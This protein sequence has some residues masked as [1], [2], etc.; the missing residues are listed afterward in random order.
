MPIHITRVRVTN[1]RN[2]RAV[3]LDNLASAVALFGENRQGKTSLL[4]AV[5][6][7][8]FGWCQ[9]TD[10]RGSHPERLIRDGAKSA[11]VEL[12]LTAGDSVIAVVMELKPRGSEWIA[13]AASGEIVARK[14]EELWGL[15]G[16]DERQ[17]QVCA[18][19]AL[20]LESGEAAE[21]MAATLVGHIDTEALQR[22]FGSERSWVTD[23]AAKKRLSLASAQDLTALGDKAYTER[24]EIRR[25]LKDAQAQYEPAPVPV[26]V[27][28]RPL[29]V[30]DLT[31]I[32]TGV[33]TVEVRRSALLVEQGR[34]QAVKPAAE[35]E[36]ELAD[37]QAAVERAK[38]AQ[39]EAGN[40]YRE[41]KADLSK[42]DD[43]LQKAREALGNA[44]MQAR[45][46]EAEASRAKARLDAV[47]TEDG[48]CPTCERK[49]TDALP[50][51]LVE[52]LDVC[53]QELGGLAAKWAEAVESSGLMVESSRT[54]K[55]LAAQRECD[56]CEAYESAKRDLERAA[57]R[58]EDLAVPAPSSRPAADIEAELAAVESKL[59]RG[60]ELVAA[61]E[62]LAKAEDLAKHIAF[63]EEELAHL[64]WAV[65]S[66]R[67]GELTKAFMGSGLDAFAARATAELE[68]FGYAL[69]VEVD[70]KR[71]TP[72]L[73]A[74][75][76]AP[77]PLALCSQGEQA[78]AALSVAL[79]FADCGAPVLVDELNTLDHV[80]RRAVL[81]R[82]REH[83]GGSL[84]VAGAWQSNA[85]VAD[86]ASALDPATV[87]WVQ[88]G[89]ASVAAG[90]EEAA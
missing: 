18:M 71:V 22:E 44:Q 69:R 65:K 70:G 74:A 33:A 77:R 42:A 31:R 41:A 37:A 40:I 80:L 1:F 57:Q 67:D 27:Q 61:L 26:D 45:T 20:Y 51:K 53:L 43:A 36:A 21:V 12:T 24:T 73:C 38:Q 89:A 14:R 56:A 81:K 39:V 35:S 50:K 55:D 11:T 82:L 87:V 19:P 17:A 32:R 47:Q 62:A 28:G 75:G 54:A 25:M 58:L 23:Y 16:V 84:W 68:R 34:A 46:A 90:K 86:L 52:P 78:L 88:D 72:A 7:A 10:R 3:A 30:G 59:A 85:D 29:T 79:A 13:T 76:K 63:C 64:D 4:A 60:R 15:L 8:L 6:Y 9:F 5:C 2:L 83:R 48:C 49:L 66:F